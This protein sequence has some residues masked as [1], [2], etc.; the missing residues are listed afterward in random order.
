MPDEH[1]PPVIE[2]EIDNIADSQ[3][4][5]TGPVNDS[6]GSR[7]RKGIALCLSGGGYRAALFHL[8]ALTR[9]NQL[10][11]L[12]QVNTFSCVSGGSTIGGLLARLIS[13]GYEPIDGHY[14][15]WA[16][17][18]IEPFCEFASTDI[19]T[20][21][22]LKRL[23]VFNQQKSVEA[24]VRKYD[25]IAEGK[26]LKQLKQQPRFIFCATDLA[27]STS[28]VSEV[29]RVGSWRAGYVIP[30]PEHWTLARSIAASSCFPPVF[31]PMKAGI[32]SD[33]F[34]FRSHM[35]DDYDEGDWER[36]RND[37]QLTD[38]GVYDNLGIEPA[39]KSH[40]T[41]LVS[42]GGASLQ[43]AITSGIHRLMRYN[44]VIQN[45]VWSLRVR[46]LIDV[47]KRAKLGQD[48]TFD[49]AY[50]GITG[51]PRKQDGQPDD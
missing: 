43:P 14:P 27:F 41:V 22:A 30:P 40:K 51:S 47:Y 33:K 9:L 34:K 6:T 26:H 19:R 10:G 17:T 3:N 4:P 7:E 38:G 25:D 50:W 44:G 24:L 36:L 20:G 37:L 49:G 39:W 42:D 28:W 8:G 46:W 15:E 13:D 45:Q 18:V 21:P 16:S 5:A 31:P 29:W 35:P 2:S 48:D 32:N 1:H 11:V 12:S 23:H